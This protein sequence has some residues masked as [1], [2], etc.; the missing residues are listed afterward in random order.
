[1]ARLITDANLSQPGA[2]EL[3]AELIEAMRD[4]NEGD[5]LA[6][7]ARLVLLLMN[8]IGD[9]EVVRQA[10]AQAKLRSS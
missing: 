1:M 10:I 6:F 9:P 8:H 4:M 7:S 5:A 3:Y 2:D